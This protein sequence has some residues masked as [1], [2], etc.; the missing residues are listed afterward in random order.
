VT[1]QAINHITLGTY[2]PKNNRGALGTKTAIQKRHCQDGGPR[3][4][5]MSNP[6][7]PKST[8]T[9]GSENSSQVPTLWK[10]HEMLEPMTRGSNVPDATNWQKIRTTSRNAQP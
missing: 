9:M 8:T 2:Q 7:S 5:Q 3:D 6:Y 1:G 10:E 4:G